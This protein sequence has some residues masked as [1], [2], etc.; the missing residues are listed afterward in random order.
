L[1]YWE[2]G[3]EVVQRFYHIITCVEIAGKK[4]V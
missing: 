4:R 2:T 1:A 3:L